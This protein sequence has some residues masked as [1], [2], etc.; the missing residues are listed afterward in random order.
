[1]FGKKKRKAECRVVARD[2]SGAV[3]MDVAEGEF[4]LPEDVT[5]SVGV[6]VLGQIPEIASPDGGYTYWT[7][8][9][10]GVIRDEIAQTE[11]R[12]RQ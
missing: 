8:E 6:T 10:G 5:N 11:A 4:A 7:L 12:Q 1:M 3:L 9:K 2:A